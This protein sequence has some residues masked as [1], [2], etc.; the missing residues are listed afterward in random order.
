MVNAQF[1][2]PTH[3]ADLASVILEIITNLSSQ[4][5]KAVPSS[6]G[7]YHYS[8]EGKITWFEF[9]EAIKEIIS[10]TT[11]IQAISTAE[12]PTA[13]KRPAWSV[14]DRE[15]IVDTFG[16]EIKDWEKSLRTCLATKMH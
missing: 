6:R 8:N 2:A 11:N 15:K 4:K 10:A 1:G 5:E 14:L 12:F 9:A 16:I 7:V 3:A 13:A